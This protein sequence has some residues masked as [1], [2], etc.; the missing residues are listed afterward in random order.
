MEWF[1]DADY[2][3]GRLLFQRGLAVVY[4]VAFVSVACQFRALIGERGLLA[5]LDRH[6]ADHQTESS[7]A[8]AA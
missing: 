8:Q 6:T 7:A 2:W 3:L 4:L 1:T 5:R